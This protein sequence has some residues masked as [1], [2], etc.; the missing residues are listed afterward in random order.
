MKKKILC[1]FF[2]TLFIVFTFPL[3]IFAEDMAEEQEV[4]LTATK[5]IDYDFKYVFGMRFK[6]EDFK[7]DKSQ[8]DIYYITSIEGKKDGEKDFYLYLYNP[9]RINIQKVSEGNTVTFTHYRS[10]NEKILEEDAALENDYKKVKLELINFHDDTL[11]S[12][13]A[14]NALILKYKIDLPV[15]YDDNIERNYCIG[16]IELAHFGGSVTNYGL[17]KRFKIYNTNVEGM[18]FVNCVEIDLKGIEMPAYHTFYR[19]NSEGVDRYTDIQSVYFPVPNKYLQQYNGLYSLKCVWDVCSLNNAVAIDNQSM[20]EKFEK[21]LSTYGPTNDSFKYSLVFNLLTNVS[22]GVL[23]K[24]SYGYAYNAVSMRDYIKFGSWR[25]E[26]GVPFEIYDYDGD[27]SWTKNQ[28]NAPVTDKYDYPLSMAFYSNNITNHKEVCVYGEEIIDYLNSHSSDAANWSNKLCHKFEHKETEFTVEDSSVTI[29]SYDEVNKNFLGIKYLV[30]SELSNSYVYNSF[31]Q[32]NKGD[33]DT[34]TKEQFSNKYY[35]DKN[36]VNCNGKCGNC[37][38]CHVT[39]DEYKDCTWFLLRYDTTYYQAYDALLL[40]NEEGKSGV[41]NACVFNTQAINNFDIIYIRFKG[42]ADNPYPTFLWGRSPSQ[43]AADAIPPVPKPAYPNSDP[44][45]FQQFLE[46]LEEFLKWIVVILAI[47]V[48]L[49][50]FLPLIP[51]TVKHKH[52][53]PRRK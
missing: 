45:K 8:T 40:D 7:E 44:D 53:T 31:M 49:E 34:L 12:S 3:S 48:V 29:K 46:M 41:A 30:E 32:I 38:K 17:N 25:V 5:S 50:I 39:S 42:D 6:V 36:D 2:A 21:W 19:V 14:T 9:S 11:A 13:D 24:P 1:I 22:V 51:T 16:D 37:M 47:S 26:L 52:Y 35:V 33:F 18:K 27:F 43:T 28:F 4:D 10:E 23:T 20:V 15:L